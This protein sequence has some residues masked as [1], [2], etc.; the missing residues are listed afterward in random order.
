MSEWLSEFT[1]RIELPAYFAGVALLGVIAT[2]LIA[3]VTV[4]GHALKI[5]RTSPIHALR[6]E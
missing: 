4:A 6:Y 5:S 2:L 1:H 3:W